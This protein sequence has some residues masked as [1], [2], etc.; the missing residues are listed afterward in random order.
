MLRIKNFGLASVA[1][2]LSEFSFFDNFFP[3]LANFW[4]LD[5]FFDLLIIFLLLL[6]PNSLTSPSLTPNPLGVDLFNSIV[7][8]NIK[9]SGVAI[10][11]KP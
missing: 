1:P 10:L 4:D 9:I 11:L 6:I 8:F 2:K 5:D 7:V 3:D